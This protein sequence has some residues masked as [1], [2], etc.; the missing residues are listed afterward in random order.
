MTVVAQDR[1]GD[2]FLREAIPHSDYLFRHAWRLTNQ[3]VDA[4]DLLQ[5]TLLKAFLAFD[6]TR[7]GSN[8]RSWLCQIMVNTW[9]D[10][11]RWVHRRPLEQLNADIS[12]EQLVDHAMHSG[13]GPRSAEAEALKLLP[14]HAAHALRTLPEDLRAAIYYADVEGYRNT[15][16]AEML[17]IPVG[18]VASRLHRGRTR[19]REILAERS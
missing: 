13:D 19:L 8:M 4:E 9:V 17:D 12:D 16:I 14:G 7:E 18:T 1:P 15:E 6:R 10:R 5:E 11:Y 2:R 3:R